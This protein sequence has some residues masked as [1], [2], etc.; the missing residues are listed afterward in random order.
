MTRIIGILL[1]VGAL[2]MAGCAA[3]P[4]ADPQSVA[5]LAQAIGALAPEV[6]PAEA[7]RAAEIAHSYPL[8]LKSEWQITDPPLVHNAKVHA[9]LRPRGLCNQWAEDMRA[10]LEA[11][12]FRTLDFDWATSPPTLFR[13]IHHTAVVSAA[14]DTVMEGIVLDPWRYSGQLFWAPL[15]QDTAYNWRPSAEV[16][17]ELARRA[18]RV[19]E[20]RTDR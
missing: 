7:R 19:A 15:R 14:G 13:I 5:R 12:E 3:P 9:G 1:L 2:A 18:E 6:D 8:Q 11:E 20:D 17:A 16:H 10:R 4:P